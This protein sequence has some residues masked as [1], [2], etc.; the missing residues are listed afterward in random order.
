MST[1][2]RDRILDSVDTALR[3]LMRLTELYSYGVKV[4]PPFVALSSSYGC[5]CGLN[6]ERTAR[7]H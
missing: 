4:S 6:R 2:L 1:D 3:G 7:T 5:V